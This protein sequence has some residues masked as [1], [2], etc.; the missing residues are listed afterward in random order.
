TPTGCCSPT[1]FS[2]HTASSW[3]PCSPCT[4]PPGPMP[5]C[6][7]PSTASGATGASCRGGSPRWRACSASTGPARW[8]TSRPPTNGCPSGSA[9]TCTSPTSRRSSPAS[10]SCSNDDL[11]PIGWPGSGGEVLG[12]ALA[13]AVALD[14][15]GV[16][17]GEGVHELDRAGVLV[18]G[19]G[20]FGEGL[21]FGG[22]GL[23]RGRARPQHHVRLHDRAPLGVRRG[24]HAGL[25]HVGV[26]EQR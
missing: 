16:G 24:D 23:V 19:D 4:P 17:A 15:A 2:R 18:G 12:G 5:S 13:E 21:E 8:T 6:V 22:L 1:S 14:L 9:P 11:I 20:L 3:P 10:H 25:D 26:A 7:R